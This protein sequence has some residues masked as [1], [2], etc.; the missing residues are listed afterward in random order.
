MRLYTVLVLYLFSFTIA[1]PIQLVT[2]DSKIIRESLEA[3]A[4][5]LSKLEYGMNHVPP[6]GSLEEAR[7]ITDYLL[8]IQ[9]EYVEELRKGGR[10]I[11]R[12]PMAI[13]VEI[14]KL[15]SLVDEVGARLHSAM[16]GWIKSKNM[17]VAA[18]RK[19][20]VLDRL[21]ATSDAMI[22]FSEAAISKLPPTT[23]SFGGTFKNQHEGFIEAAISAYRR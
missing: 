13:A 12:G 1:S 5:T 16:N 21:L 3:I 10:D 20:A 19:E 14:P 8:G 11:R 18:G 23:H 22:V 4:S 7:K 2:R 9:M 6:G 17:A 15:I